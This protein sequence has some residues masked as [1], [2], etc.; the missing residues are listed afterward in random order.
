VLEGLRA[1][2]DAL[3]RDDVSRRVLAR[4]PKDFFSL[5]TAIGALRLALMRRYVAHFRRQELPTNGR[6]LWYELEDERVVDKTK[7]RGHPGVKG[8]GIDQTLNGA[9][10]DLRERGLVPWSAIADETRSLTNYRGYRSTLEGALDRLDGVGLDP[11][12]LGGALAP[13]ILCESRSLAG[14]LQGLAGEYRCLITSTN[15]QT[16]GHL[17]TEVAPV[18]SPLSDERAAGIAGPRPV[19]YL[20]DWDHQGGQIEANDRKVLAAYPGYD[21]DAWERVALTDVQVRSR[22]LTPILKYDERYVPRRAHPA[23]ETEALGQGLIVALLRERLEFLLP[24][25][26]ADVQVR[27]REERAELRRRLSGEG[28]D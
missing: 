15:G 1:F 5:Q 6:F 10:T 8:R 9:L 12:L 25:P 27:E 23:V 17:H 20:G 19:L 18:L 13:L 26:L 4:L 14:V 2:L 7:A 24:V 22:G 16:A 28:A 21:E 11:W 3:L